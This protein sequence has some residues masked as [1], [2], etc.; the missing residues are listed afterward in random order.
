MTTTFNPGEPVFDQSTGEPVIDPVT[1]DF[2]EVAPNS[3]YINP[4]TG[5]RFDGDD[6][7]N[8]AYFRANTYL[9][10]VQRDRSRGVDFINFVF[11][12]N[13]GIDVAVGE[14][15]AAIRLTPGV[16]SITDVAVIE[17]NPATRALQ[18]RYRVRKR[19]GEATSATTR[20]AG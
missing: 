19:S 9:G 5:V 17:F 3:E 13:V 11:A 10:E 14:L 12:G 15:S 18:L 4:L 16:Q 6:V 8:A 20:I 7:A 1:G 2:V